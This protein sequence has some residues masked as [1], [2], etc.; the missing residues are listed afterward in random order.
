M[1]GLLENLLQGVAGL[2]DKY[3]PGQGSRTV[4]V[5]VLTILGNVAMF[6]VGQETKQVAAN[7]ILLAAGLIF[8]ALHQPKPPVS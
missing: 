4:A 1:G 8:A 3:V 7:N 5:A 2:L 6:L